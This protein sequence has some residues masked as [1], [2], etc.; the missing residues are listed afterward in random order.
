[1]PAPV[2]RVRLT[3]WVCECVPVCMCE[4]VYVCMCPHGYVCVC[5]CVRVG[6]VCVRVC[7]ARRTDDRVS[8]LLGAVGVGVHMPA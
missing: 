3:V 1:M 5:T 4:H 8:A 7:V 2:Q 6:C